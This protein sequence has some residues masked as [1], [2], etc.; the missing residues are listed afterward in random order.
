MELRQ[1]SRDPA[2][3]F[4]NIAP[5]VSAPT[6]REPVRAWIKQHDCSFTLTD[7]RKALNLPR[8]F[9]NRELNRMLKAGLLVRI[10]TMSTKIGVQGDEY[11]CRVY[12]YMPTNMGEMG[13]LGE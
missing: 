9:I 10:Y 6:V 12:L 8:M 5:H 11:P 1:V 2:E 3:L 13:E 4:A 7:I